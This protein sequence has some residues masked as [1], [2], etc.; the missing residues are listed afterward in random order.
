[1]KSFRNPKYLER[2]EDIVFDLE[3]PLLTPADTNYQN[4]EGIRIVADNTGDATP[5]DWYNSRLSV[6][7]KVDILADHAALTLT[8]HKG[9][10]NGSNTL[11]KKLSITAN[12]RQVYNCDYANHCVNIKNLLEY[13]P[14][15]AKSVGTNEFYFPDTTRHTDEIKYTK[16]QV[17]HRRNAADNADDKEEM[18]DDVNVNYNKG[19]AVRKALLGLSAKVNCEIPLN[20][21]SFFEALEDKLL[22]NTKIELNIEFDDDKNLIWRQGAANADGSSYRLI[23]TRLRLLFQD[24]YLIQRGKSCTWKIISNHTNGLT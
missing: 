23:I 17:T 8:E 16:R 15:Y 19:F 3:Q 12:G 2:Y 4:R 22:P 18:L 1:M 5:F 9:I 14:S 6:D 10:V 24:W 21:Y 20:R 11:I 7:F 13:N